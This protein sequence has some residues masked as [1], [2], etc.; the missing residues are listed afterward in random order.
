MSV[1]VPILTY[2]G[3]LAALLL[4]FGKTR[5]HIARADLL[6]QAGNTALEKGDNNPRGRA[7]LEVVR[8]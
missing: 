2:A 5:W 1:F 3:P 4:A 8:R 6:K 7:A